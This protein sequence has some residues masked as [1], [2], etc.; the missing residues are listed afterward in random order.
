MERKLSSNKDKAMRKTYIIPTIM[1]VRMQTT[2]LVADSGVSSNNGI[3][4]GGKVGED[5]GVI[6]EVKMSTNI[7]DS[8]W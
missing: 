6:P 3:D 5:D 7:W 1:V 2:H 8:D 4:Y